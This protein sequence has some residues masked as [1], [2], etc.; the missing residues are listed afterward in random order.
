M[1]PTSRPSEPINDLEQK[2]I[3]EPDTKRVKGGGSGANV[4][5]NPNVPKPWRTLVGPSIRV[6]EEDAVVT[7]APAAD[8]STS[9]RCEMIAPVFASLYNVIL[10]ASTLRYGF[11][12]CP[13]HLEESWNPRRRRPSRSTISNRRRFANQTPKP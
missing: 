5:K 7:L 11:S 3:R 12:P 9:G 13:Q 10:R 4:P 8:S 2:E 6:G 1:E